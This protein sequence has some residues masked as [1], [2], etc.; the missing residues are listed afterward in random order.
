[1]LKD[2]S[3]L[4]VYMYMRSEAFTLGYVLRY[5]PADSHMAGFHSANII[6]KLNFDTRKVKNMLTNL[7]FFMVSPDNR[8][9]GG[10]DRQR[11][12]VA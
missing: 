2:I 11:Q 8:A 6:Q 7:N 4:A 10:A 3:T 12:A 9:E 1:M 5:T